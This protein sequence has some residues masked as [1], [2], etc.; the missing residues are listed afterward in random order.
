MINVLVVDDSAFMRMTIRKMLE[1]DPSI[2]VIGIAR[3]GI[4]AVKKASILNPDVITM[5]ITMPNMDGIQAVE[6][7]MSQNPIPIIIISAITRVGA[8]ATIEALEKGAVDYISKDELKPGILLQKIHIAAQAK[9]KHTASLDNLVQSSAQPPIHDNGQS[10]S[11]VGIGIS[12]GGPKALNQVIPFLSAT[13]PVGILI[14]QHM[15]P[16]FT[17]SL[18]EHLDTI[19]KIKVTE[20]QNGEKILPG[21]AYICP[22]GMHMIIEKRD[23]ITLYPKSAFNYLYVPSADLLM[24]SIGNVYGPEGLCIIMTGMGTDGLAGIQSAKKR[25]SYVLAQSETSSII[26]GMPKAIIENNLHDEIVDLKN[27]AERINYLCSAN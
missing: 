23:T 18:A 2:K 16:L 25:G 8:R 5:D 27:M 13:L 26:Y 7:I 14:A 24:S 1:T 15:P 11:I 12:T 9:Y 4:E 21:H 10:F 19:S 22:G 17:R 6:K 20:A 3:D